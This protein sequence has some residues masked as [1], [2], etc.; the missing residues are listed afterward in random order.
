MGD[1]FGGSGNG[2]GNIQTKQLKKDLEKTVE[3]ANAREADLQKAADQARSLKD[4]VDILRETSD[5]VAK[6]EATIESY[7][8]KLEDV[9]D[10][11]RQLKLLE[12]KNTT[13]V[14][15]NMDLEEDVKKTG[16]WKPQIDVY[17]RQISELHSKLEA[18]N[19]RADKSDF[20]T[21]RLL[22]K[23]EALS[24]ER[25]RLQAERDS[26]KESNAELQDQ[27]KLGGSG[28]VTGTSGLVDS[29]PDSG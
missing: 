1:E 7:K 2:G 27:V 8:K 21:K 29:E 23:T 16:N 10:V 4:E 6:Y 18:E 13:L 19:N 24:V 11:K 26:L 14:Q 28:G 5:K 17:K 12:E 25:D 15:T 9:G 22:E 3:E 20:E